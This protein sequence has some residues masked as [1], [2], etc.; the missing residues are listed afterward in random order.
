MLQFPVINFIIT[1]YA[2]IIQCYYT[3]FQK[4]RENKMKIFRI[5]PLVLIICLVMA[6]AAPGAYALEDP[7][8]NGKAALL[9]D[10]DTGDI[11]YE[12]N[13]DEQRAPASLTKIMTTLLA[14]EALDEGRISLEDMVTAQN[15]C[16]SGMAEDS[17]T[18]GITPGMQ[19]SVKDLLY[20]TMLHSANEACNVL[21][22][23]ISGSISAFVEEMNAKAAQLGGFGVHLLH[24]GADAAG[25]VG[26]QHVAGLVGGVEHGAVEQVLHGQLHSRSN[27]GGAAVLRHAG[28]AVVLG[29]D[30]ILQGDAPLVQSLQGQQGGHYLGEAGGG[31]LLVLVQLIEDIPRVQVH[32][33]GG[34]AVEAGVFQGVGSRG[35]ESHHQAYDKHQWKDAENFH[36]VL[37]FFLE[38]G[39]VALYNMCILRYYKIYDRKLQHKVPCSA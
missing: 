25:D 10:L 21:G 39:I 28:E 30:H 8:L 16:L 26:A 38:Y 37:P 20:C 23:Y 19:L 27:A 4:K 13:K 12:L 9:V 31:P 36:F 35:G 15:D 33:Q 1:K 14:L 22:T 24:E 5:F 11:L 18:A 7:S 3:I 32:Q 29:G 6:F 17:S 2:H 34:L